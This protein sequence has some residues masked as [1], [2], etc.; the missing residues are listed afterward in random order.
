MKKFYLLIISLF[1]LTGNVYNQTL[2][3][4]FDLVNKKDTIGQQRLLE[5]WEQSKPNDP[6]LY[7]AYFNFYYLKSMKEVITLGQNPKGKDGFQI[8]DTLTKQPVGYMY[9][10]KY[11]EPSIIIKGFGYID[12]GIE[13]FPTRLDMRFGK[14]F[15]FGEMSD[16]GNFTK[17]IIS[18]IDYSNVINNK[19][20]WKDNKPLEDPKNYMLGT[21]QNYQ[22]QLYNTGN[23]SL[24]NNMAMIS[25][26]ILKYYPDHVESLSNLSIVYL[27][28]SKF[29]DALELLLKAEKINPK[30]FIILGNIAQTFK[31]KGDDSNAIK[32]YEL[33]IKYGDNQ[34]KQN[35]REQILQIKK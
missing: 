17:E 9:D 19:W 2:Q 31:R 8:L 18:A 15:A 33:V 35:A 12:R 24:L 25:K 32:Y 34:A 27:I 11:F 6:D 22:N 13:K 7:V 16:Y 29:D 28:Q 5:K 10:G 1:L 21:I 20:L 26:A 30:D 14:V 4:F 3:Q 23:D